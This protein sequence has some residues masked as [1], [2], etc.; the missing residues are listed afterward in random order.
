VLTTRGRLARG[1]LPVA[2]ATALLA[3][4][5][6]DAAP[7]GSA[8]PTSAASSTTGPTSSPTD[9][10]TT[11]AEAYRAARTASLS[12]QSGHAKGTVT[13][14]GAVLGIDVE[15]LANGSNQTVFITTPDGGTAEVV[16]V[17]NGYWVGGDEGYWAETTGDPANAAKLV[18]KYAPITESDATELGSFD[19]RTLLTNTFSMP[20]FT[21]L[22]SDTGEATRAEVDGQPAFVLGREGGARMWVAA[23]GSGALLRVVGPTTDAFDLTFTDWDRARTFDQPAPA[24]LLE[25]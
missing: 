20:E 15:G 5:T 3:G 24:D 12:A 13:R 18:G 23:D 11:V 25:N 6:D 2:V 10:A 1:L 16:T 14:E 21:V 19:L 8:S 17:G 22:E 9:P 7:S 4:C